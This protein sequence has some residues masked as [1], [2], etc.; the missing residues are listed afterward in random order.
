MEKDS[1]W[2]FLV[3]VYIL[4]L[5]FGFPLLLWG[6]QSINFKG[7]KW[8]IYSIHNRFLKNITCIKWFILNIPLILKTN[9][10]KKTFRISQKTT[11]MISAS[12]IHFFSKLLFPKYSKFLPIYFIFCFHSYLNSLLLNILKNTWLHVEIAF[13]FWCCFLTNLILS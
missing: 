2:P 6:C 10:L 9:F 13:L 11:V 4:G 5:E 8:L 12:W 7:I 1:A 3:T